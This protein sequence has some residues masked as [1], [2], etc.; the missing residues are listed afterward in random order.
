M[1]ENT[2]SDILYSYVK[3]K[4]N[5][6]GIYTKHNFQNVD[7]EK[8]KY[9]SLVLFI[10]NISMNLGHWC[11]ITKIENNIY[12]LDSFSLHPEKYGIDLKKITNSKKYRFFYL[13]QRTQNDQT[14]SCGGHSIY[15]IINTIKCKYKIFCFVNSFTQNFS[16]T[17]FL[18]NENFIVEYLSK[19]FPKYV[20]EKNCEKLF[21]N[22]QFI[23]NRQECLKSLCNI[24]I[25]ARRV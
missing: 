20:N 5:F 24:S 13:T 14:T 19:T 22:S 21:C 18:K 11:V 17:N 6:L 23:I 7:F 8:Y 12:F 16:K 15:Y 4:D 3:D 10:D 9:C 2:I 1:D 25:K